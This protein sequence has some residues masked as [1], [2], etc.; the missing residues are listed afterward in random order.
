MI[1]LLLDCIGCLIL[2]LPACA[3]GAYRRMILISVLLLSV[4]GASGSSNKYGE[5]VSHFKAQ[6]LLGSTACLLVCLFYWEPGWAGAAAL[7]VAINLAA[8]APWYMGGKKMTTNR[9][10]RRRVKLILANVNHCNADHETFLAFAKRHEPD[11]LVVQEVTEA[12]RESMQALLRFR[13]FRFTRALRYEASIS[14]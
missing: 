2:D 13:S 5:L 3:P 9:D 11:A 7:G 14:S 1:A 12:W 6:Y 8:V 10:G 4:A